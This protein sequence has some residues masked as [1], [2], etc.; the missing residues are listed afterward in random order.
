MPEMYFQVRWPDGETQRCYSPSTVIADFLSPGT[1]YPIGD[2]VERSRRALGIASDRVR[3]KF[4]FACS[5]AA[6]QLAEI[7]EIAARYRA[8]PLQAVTVETITMATTGGR[9]VTRP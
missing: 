8:S 2:F 3:D 5:A 1:A 6:D 7:E 4:G 9:Q